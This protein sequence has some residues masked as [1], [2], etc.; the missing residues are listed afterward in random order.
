MHRRRL[1]A[2]VL[3]A[4]VAMALSFGCGSSAGMDGGSDGS[5]ENLILIYGQ[6][7][8]SAADPAFLDDYIEPVVEAMGRIGLVRLDGAP[9]KIAPG[10][11]GSLDDGQI[12]L[13]SVNKN[14][15]DAEI[16]R[17]TRSLVDDLSGEGLVA[18]SPEVDIMAAFELAARGLPKDGGENVVVISDPGISTKGWVNFTE[19]G[20][21]AD[22]EGFVDWAV[23]EGVLPDLSNIDEIVWYCFGDVAAPQPKPKPST[24]ESMKALWKAV[25]EAC[26]FAGELR[27][28]DA[29]PGAVTYPDNLPAVSVIEVPNVS[30]YAGQEVELREDGGVHFNPDEDTFIDESAAEK[31]LA[32]YVE[33]LEDPTLQVHVRGYVSHSTDT[34]HLEGE[35]AQ[36]R[37][38]AVKAKL[39][40]MG[41]P[42][43]QIIVDDSGD[44]LGPYEYGEDGKSDSEIDALNRF[45]LLSF[46]QVQ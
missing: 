14:S 6:H 15:Q 7:A 36:L 42:S 27:F 31:T 39:V 32:E 26:G 13:K 24:I 2:V 8:N 9:A 37:A 44:G 29:A 41:V 1:V 25:L 35:L 38:E 10:A 5:S 43:S 46:E 23:N 21:E 45:V 33:W 12:V 18:Q 40:E 28:E 3:V 16:A 19:I 17:I 11:F 34:R 30:P 20:L 22:A 4:L